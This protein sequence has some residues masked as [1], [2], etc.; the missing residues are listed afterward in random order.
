MDKL[1]YIIDGLNEGLYIVED[2]DTLKSIASKFKTTKNLI[3]MDNY[4][5]DEVKKGDY[6]YIKKYNRLYVVEPSD[7]LESISEKFSISKEEI[8]RVN[9]IKYI[10][11]TQK[12]II[13]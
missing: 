3:I 8:L 13:D 5:T 7:S 4:L 10:Y 11:P 9:K 1:S 12:I 2:G 6:L